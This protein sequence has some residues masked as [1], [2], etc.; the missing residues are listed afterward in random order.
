MPTTLTPPSQKE[1][2]S[3]F[4]SPVLR[5]FAT[6]VTGLLLVVYL[7]QHLQ[8]NLRIFSSD[9]LAVS[10]YGHLLEGFGVLLR[11][12]EIGLALVVGIH[13]LIGIAIWIQKRKARPADYKR[14]ASKGSPSKQTFASRTMIWSGL[15]LAVFLVIHVAYFRF[16]PG[17]A[18]GY[19]VQIDGESARHY[20]RLVTE[21][22]QHVGYV[23]FY[24]IAMLAVGIHLSH[25]FWSALQSVG[26]VNPK[27]RELLYRLSLV[28]G[29]V[30]TLGFISIPLYVYFS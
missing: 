29:G 5:K 10:K 22:F 13:A 11:F 19:A 24:C 15:L 21:R 30:A 20:E 17:L 9:P 3:L 28:I 26:L 8:A 14:Y 25:G 4:E 7:A 6:G 27:N 16:G 18:E 2:R 23:I 12:I 1:A